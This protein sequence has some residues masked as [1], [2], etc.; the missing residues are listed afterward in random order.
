M[1]VADVVRCGAQALAAVLVLSGS[2]EVW[3]LAAL[4]GLRSRSMPRATR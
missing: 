4:N 1:I 2:A 3:H